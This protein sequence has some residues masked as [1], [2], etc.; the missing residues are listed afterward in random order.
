MNK[1]EIR[2]AMSELA[3]LRWAKTTKKQRSEHG[4]KM[5][6]ARGKN[7]EKPIQNGA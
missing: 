6:T 3:K 7:T 4:K 5:R 1:K 2:S